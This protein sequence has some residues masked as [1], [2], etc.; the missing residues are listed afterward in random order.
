MARTA[1]AV[2]SGASNHERRSSGPDRR[3]AGPFPGVA[4]DTVGDAFCAALL[5]KKYVAEAE[6]PESGVCGRL[7]RS[8]RGGGL[9]E[10]AALSARGD[11]VPG[12][13]RRRDPRVVLDAGC[14][15]G[16]VARPL[17]PLV[18]RVDAVDISAGMIERGRRLPGGENPAITWICA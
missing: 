15:T 18:D 13:P 12:E 1:H 17:A 5:R 3:H 4:P 16:D 8:Q 7:H 6:A 10:P 14:G 9:S 2:W 11:R